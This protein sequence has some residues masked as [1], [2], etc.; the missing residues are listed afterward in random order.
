M[1]R[2]FQR[3]MHVYGPQGWWPVMEQGMIRYHPG[4]YS[5]PKT[6]EQAFEVCAGA[7]LTQNT[8]WK[9]VEKALATL[10]GIDAAALATM[11]RSVLARHIRPSGYFNQK[12]ERLQLFAQTVHQAGG[13]GAFLEKTHREQLLSLKGIGPE[14]ADS[15]LLY[16]KKEPVFVVDAYTKRIF[17]RYGFV[18]QDATYDEIQDLVHRTLKPVVKAYNEFHALLVEHA[19]QYCTPKPAC[20]T[21]FLRKLCNQTF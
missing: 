14:T 10:R 15:I 1:K 16:A 21:C 3:F 20:G 11:K 17:S 13:I 4:D 8:S 6:A 9:N 7:I 19:K 5:Y 18:A 2:L 12:A